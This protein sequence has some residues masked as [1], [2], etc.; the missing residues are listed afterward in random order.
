[1]KKIP[2]LFVRDRDT[3]L[4]TPVVTSGCEWVTQGLGVATVK[5]DGTSCLYFQ[6]RLW[7]RYTLK[8]GKTPPDNFLYAQ[9]EPDPITG[10][11]PGWI[12]VVE[13]DK[14][15]IEALQ[16]FQNDFGEPIEGTYELIGPKV[17]GNPYGFM[18]DHV[19]IRHGVDVVA[20]APRTFEALYTFLSAPGFF[21]EG[22]V[23][24]YGDGV[25]SAKIKRRDFGLS[26]PQLKELKSKE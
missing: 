12:P 19:L 16:K 23:W 24:H 2:T 20:K 4:V 3:H 26:W 21:G 13:S 22:L 5:W 14:Y 9:P 15:H 18:N 6:N 25:R 8:Q 10:E 7:K 17:Q 1:M 11:L